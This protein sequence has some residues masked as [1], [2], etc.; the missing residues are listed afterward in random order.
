MF[1]RKQKGRNNFL[2]FIKTRQTAAF[3][4]F[5]PDGAGSCAIIQEDS[6]R[7]DDVMMSSHQNRTKKKVF[8][9]KLTKG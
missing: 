7:E 2:F 8:V 5:W 3:N 1:W 9:Y 6:H 4:S